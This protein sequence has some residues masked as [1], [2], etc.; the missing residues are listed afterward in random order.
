MPSPKRVSHSGLG[1][2]VDEPD[3]QER[4]R[5]DE[6]ERDGPRGRAGDV[7]LGEHLALDLL[8]ELGEHRARV[9]LPPGGDPHLDLRRGGDAEVA[10]RHELAQRD[11]NAAIGEELA[12]DVGR[13]LVAQ[14]GDGDPLR[15]LF[16]RCV[17]HDCTGRGLTVRCSMGFS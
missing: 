14:G 7:C 10:V 9:L 16:R 12:R 15:R 13:A 2:R 3:R 6:R 5:A 17:G 8:G 1:A 11:V 4:H